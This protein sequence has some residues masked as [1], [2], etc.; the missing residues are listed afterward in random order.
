MR[1]N[2]F[3]AWSRSGLSRRPVKI[4][5]PG[6][7][8]EAVDFVVEDESSNE[9]FVETLEKWPSTRFDHH[10]RYLAKLREART[11]L[12]QVLDESEREGYPKPA[13]AALMAASDM[14]DLTEP[15]VGEQC[16]ITFATA[17]GDIVDRVSDERNNYVVLESA[18]DGSVGL[19]FSVSAL[20]EFPT[21]GHVPKQFVAELLKSLHLNPTTT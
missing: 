19:Y 3:P 7:I 5:R 2:T 16:K 18:E 17:D 14:H 12:S 11:K 9:E 10:D 15:I 1:R 8:T 13:N 21:A 20:R 4:G 6:R